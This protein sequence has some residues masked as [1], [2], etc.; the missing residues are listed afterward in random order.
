MKSVQ[1]SGLLTDG[2]LQVWMGFVHEELVVKT[3]IRKQIN[4]NSG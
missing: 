2:P 3:N 1:I 4:R